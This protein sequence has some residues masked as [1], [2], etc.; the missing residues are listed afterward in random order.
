MVLNEDDIPAINN[1][2]YILRHTIH[3]TFSDYKL[4]FQHNELKLNVDKT[5]II[6]FILSNIPH[7]LELE[8]KNYILTSK[9]KNS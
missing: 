9:D 8:E 2:L 7:R 6:I 5:K 3:D 1:T 4:A